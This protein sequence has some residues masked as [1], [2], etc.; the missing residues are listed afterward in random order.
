MKT[1]LLSVAVALALATSAVPQNTACPVRLTGVLTYADDDTVL[2]R[3]NLVKRHVI[4]EVAT[5]LVLILDQDNTRLR[6]VTVDQDLELVDE[7]ATSTR[8]VF[9]SPNQ[10]AGDLV[11]DSLTVSNDYVNFVADGTLQVR[12]TYSIGTNGAPFRISAKLMGVINDPINGASSNGPPAMFKGE[13]T[14]D[15]AGYDADEAG[16]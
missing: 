8:C 1:I 6:L 7:L 10:F 12:G 14:S 11:F 13:F 16:Y 5:K 2:T 4:G 9:L 3:I 15:G